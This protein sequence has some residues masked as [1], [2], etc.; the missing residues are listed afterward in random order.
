VKIDNVLA[1]LNHKEPDEVPGLV[2]FFDKNSYYK[3]VPKFD[4]YDWKK[5]EMGYINFLDNS[6][7][8]AGHGEL[9]SK[10]IEKRDDCYVI[11]FE[12]GAKWKITENPFNRDYIHYPIR[13]EKDIDKM[14]FPD[15]DVERYYGHKEENGRILREDGRY[16]DDNDLAQSISVEERVKF[17]KDEGLFTTGTVNGFFS[18]VW[19]FWREFQDFL[20]DLAIRQEFAEE[21]IR[22]VAEYNLRSAE[23]LLQRGVHGIRFNDDLGSTTSLLISPGFYEKYFYPWHKKLADLCHRYNAYLIIHSHGNINKLIPLFIK[24]GIDIIHPVGPTDNIK[25]EEIKD[26]YGET[27]TFFGGI[28]K[29][30]GEMSKQEMEVHVREVIRA[31]KHGGGFILGEEGGIPHSMSMDDFKFYL[32]LLQKYRED[33]RR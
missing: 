27:V 33:K 7:V 26:L 9:R 23:N 6:I 20:I 18:G 25:L 28:S 30:I 8:E 12:S 11:E 16:I 22:R 5:N 1:S 14:I 3:F 13:D 2:V 10:I 29:F 15:A 21:M 32:D 31:G 17:Y 4:C 24:A 19:Y